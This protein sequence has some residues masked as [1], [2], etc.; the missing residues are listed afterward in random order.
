MNKHAGSR[1]RDLRSPSHAVPCTS[2]YSKMQCV[3]VF[4]VAL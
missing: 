3:G 1:E 2:V 4:H